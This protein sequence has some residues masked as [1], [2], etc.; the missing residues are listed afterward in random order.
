MP[1]AFPAGAWWW[2]SPPIPMPAPASPMPPPS[3]PPSPKPASS[4]PR[5]R[6]GRPLGTDAP[7]RIA[8]A[9]TAI[10]SAV[11][12]PGWLAVGDAAACL[13]PLLS[14][15]LTRALEDGIAAADAIAGAQA[16]DAGAFNAYQDR[17]FARFT[18]GVRLRAG[19]YAAETRWPDAPFWRRRQV[20]AAA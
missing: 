6:A 11:A 8:I 16:G 10:L 13:D 20:Q 4:A 9:P 2:A 15:G 12:G 5:S 17:V 3:A 14:Q 19:F 1:A 18:A 7:P